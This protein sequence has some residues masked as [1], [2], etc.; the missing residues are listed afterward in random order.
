MWLSWLFQR[1]GGR[2][3]ASFV[4]EARRAAFL[5]A[6]FLVH[7]Y[8]TRARRWAPD[9][10]PPEITPEEVLGPTD[11]ALWADA[12]A[13]AR[14]LS[15]DAAYVGM[16]YFRYEGVRHTYAQARALLRRENGGFSERCYELATDA[17]ITDM[18]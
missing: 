3:R 18:R 14:K 1:K 16:A 2:E 6:A 11:R 9:P 17:A 7:H 4:A 13:K 8:N 12:L 15:E 5:D 10:M